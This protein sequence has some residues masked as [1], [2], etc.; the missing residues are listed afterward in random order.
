MVAKYPAEFLLEFRAVDRF[1]FRVSD[2]RDLREPQHSQLF[3]RLDNCHI[4]LLGKR[5][6]VWVVPESIHATDETVQF[7]IEYKLAGLIRRRNVELLRSV[8]SPE[9]A[10]FEASPYPHRDLISRDTNGRIVTQT[11]LSNFI[12]L[13]PHVEEGAR[14][15]QIVYVG[16]GLRKSAIDRLQNHKTL[17]HILG[18]INSHEPDAE[19]FV[20]IYDFEYRKQALTFYNVPVEISGN[21]AKRRRKRALA[22]RPT[23]KE[24][25]AL[26]EASIISYFQTRQFNTHY[27]T[28]PDQKYQILKKIYEADFAAIVV[29]LDNTNIGNQ[30]TYSECVIPRSTHYIVVDFRRLE[31]KYSVLES[32]AERR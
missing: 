23:V 11:W 21:A 1:L 20:M 10:F 27:L 25:V 32:F 4:Y 3:K 18:E 24:Q 7:T 19:A 22:Y 17:Q 2:L 31:G 15:L 12:H 29:Q 6:R 30:R 16:Q 5:P 9:E 28:F 26:V 13:M 8:F 14:D